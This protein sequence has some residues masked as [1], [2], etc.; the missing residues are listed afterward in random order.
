MTTAQSLPE[1][2]WGIRMTGTVAQGTLEDCHCSCS[3]CYS[4]RKHCSMVAAGGL[5]LCS[6]PVVH[7]LGWTSLSPGELLKIR[8]AWGEDPRAVESGFWG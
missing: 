7:S 5:G 6:C 1:A 8:E 4:D 2:I 3:S